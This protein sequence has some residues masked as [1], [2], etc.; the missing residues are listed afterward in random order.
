MVNSDGVPGS[1]GNP[2]ETKYASDEE[3]SAVR[4]VT[5]G[6]AGK[7]GNR[8]TGKEGKRERGKEGKRERGK[9]KQGNREKARGNRQ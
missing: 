7:Q 3:W 2:I 8:E 4:A 1:R 9:R 5:E 6:K